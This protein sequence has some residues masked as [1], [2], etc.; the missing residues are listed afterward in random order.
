MLPILAVLGTQILIFQLAPSILANPLQLNLPTLIDSALLN[1]TTLPTVNTTILDGETCFHP[2]SD[3]HPTN[4]PDCAMAAIDMHK[5]SDMRVYTFGRGRRATYK[6]PRTFFGGTCVVNLDM[7]YDDQSD[8][9]TFEVVRETIFTLALRC[10]TGPVFKQGGSVAVGPKNVLHVTI[11]GRE[12]E[13]T[14]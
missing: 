7:V 8:R 12:P 4:Y 2:R 5:G 9:L 10:T 11:I 13:G 3:R 1:S 6:L 14:S